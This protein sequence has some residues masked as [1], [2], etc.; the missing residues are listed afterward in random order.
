V[1]ELFG[2]CVTSIRSSLPFARVNEY[3]LQADFRRAIRCWLHSG[4]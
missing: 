4:F 3:K 1:F 2:H